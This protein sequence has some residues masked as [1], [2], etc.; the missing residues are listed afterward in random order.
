MEL[1]FCVGS[2][3]RMFIKT[4][5]LPKDPLPNI[6]NFFLQWKWKIDGHNVLLSMNWL[7]L[8]KSHTA[9]DSPLCTGTKSGRKFFIRHI[10]PLGY[11]ASHC[12]PERHTDILA[13]RDH[14]RLLWKNIVY[15]GGT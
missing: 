11:M 7:F 6:C 10:L 12:L 4:H 2:S 1:L 13:V 9:H 14:V 3:A 8:S 5:I 15:G